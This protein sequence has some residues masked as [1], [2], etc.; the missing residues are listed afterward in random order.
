MSCP[1]RCVRQSVP[2][3]EAMKVERVLTGQLLVEDVVQKLAELHGCG[4]RRDG[5]TGHL[6]LVRQGVCQNRQ[7][8]KILG[9]SDGSVGH[10]GVLWVYRELAE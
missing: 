6:A 7:G 8:R 2:S 1:L 5:I 4:L 9:R 10:D 3:N